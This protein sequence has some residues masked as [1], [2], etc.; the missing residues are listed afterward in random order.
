MSSENPPH[1]L[2][3]RI[4]LERAQGFFELEMFNEAEVELRAVPENMPWLK[5]K[6]VPLI[7]L[8]QEKK[9][10]KLMKERQRFANYFLKKKIGGFRSLCSEGQIPWKRLGG[11]AGRSNA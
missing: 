7:F 2:N 4:H 6:R 5:P 10:W 9:E 1:R 8:Y 3:P 11:F